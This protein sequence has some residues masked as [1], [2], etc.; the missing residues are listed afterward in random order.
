MLRVKC[1]QSGGSSTP[2]GRDALRRHL[3]LHL[4]MSLSNFLVN[5][6]SIHTVYEH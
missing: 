2:L 6:L 3:I 1:A 5:G 4:L